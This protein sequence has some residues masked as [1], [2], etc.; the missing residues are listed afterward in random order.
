MATFN[1]YFDITRGYI[2]RELRRG[3][4]EIITSIAQLGDL[5]AYNQRVFEA[6]RAPE[7]EI[8]QRLSFVICGHHYVVTI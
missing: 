8:L 1:S 3:P 4:G 6:Q 2:V 7:V 5:N